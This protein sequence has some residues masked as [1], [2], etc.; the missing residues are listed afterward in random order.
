MLASVKNDKVK[1]G[2]NLRIVREE[3]SLTQ[4]K[5]AEKMDVDRQTVYRMEKGNYSMETFLVATLVLKVNLQDLLPK[6]YVHIEAEKS[7]SQV[8]NM[9]LYSAKKLLMNTERR[10]LK[11]QKV[12]ELLLETCQHKYLTQQLQIK[13]VER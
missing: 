4:E 7:E 13:I 12:K 5:L 8:D 6:R 9:G 11:D 10:Y 3:K 2:D 1:I